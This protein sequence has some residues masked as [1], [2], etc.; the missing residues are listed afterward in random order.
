MFPDWF[1][2]VIVA[3]IAIGMFARHYIL[4]YQRERFIR[5][6]TWPPQLLEKLERKHVG[7]SRK[8]SALVGNGLSSPVVANGR[9]YMIGSEL[10]EKPKARERVHCLDE[11]TGQQLW[12]YA[13]DVTYPEWAFDPKQNSGPNATPIFHDGKIYTLG[14]MG[15]LLCLAMGIVWGIENVS[16]VGARSR[17]SSG[18]RRCR[19]S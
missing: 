14:Q 19:A 10:V 8:E 7:F 18:I 16:V 9:V 13:Y 15:D 3:A 2:P 11:K 17:I 5:E 12:T 1:F 4:D 6:Y